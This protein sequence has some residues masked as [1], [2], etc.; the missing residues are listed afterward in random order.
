M[1]VNG[2]EVCNPGSDEAQT[3]GCRCPIVDNHYGD[4]MYKDKDG[5]AIF[6]VNMACPIHGSETKEET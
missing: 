6:V 2:K 4:G 1:I 3:E 5:V